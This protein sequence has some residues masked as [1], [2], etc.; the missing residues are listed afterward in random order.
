M[1]DRPSPSTVTDEGL[2]ERIGEAAENAV[3]S[4]MSW[5]EIG[6]VVLAASGHTALLREIEVLREALG[7]AKSLLCCSRANV[8]STMRP[9]YGNE[10]QD[11]LLDKIDAALS[12]PLDETRE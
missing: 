4:E 9:L 12:R 10:E 1:T 6:E 7:E 11:A 5:P 8:D 2:V 3:M